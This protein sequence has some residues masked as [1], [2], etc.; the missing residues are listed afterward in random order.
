MRFRILFFIFFI[1]IFLCAQ[2]T[3]YRLGRAPFLA[4]FNPRKLSQALTAGLPNDSLKVRSI[5]L[6]TT[7]HIRYDVKAFQAGRGSHTSPGAIL[8][9]RKTVCLGYSILFDS[10]CKY[11]DINAQVVPG[12]VYEPWYE[13]RD[14]F[15]LDSHAWNVVQVDGEWKII[16][17][18][19]ASGIVKMKRQYFRK[20]LE[21]L[22]H[23]PYRQK[24]KYKKKRNDNYF[25]ARP[26]KFVLDHLPSSPAWQL[27]DCSVPID[28]FQWN[29][30][31]TQHFLDAPVNCKNGFDSI[32]KI[33]TETE[34][35]QMIAEGKEAVNYNRYNHQDISLGYFINGMLILQDAEDTNKNYMER[36]ALYDSVMLQMDSAAFSFMATSHDA[37]REENYFLRRNQRMK[38]QVIAENTPLIKRQE[39]EHKQ[40]SKEMSVSRK[41]IHHLDVENEKLKLKSKIIRKQK[42]KIDR[43]EKALVNEA[44]YRAN[45]EEAI[46]TN[47]DDIAAYQDSIS[48]VTF[49]LHADEAPGYVA[50][51]KKKRQ[52]LQRELLAQRY[53]LFYR[54]FEYNSFDTVLILQKKE[55]FKC[56]KQRDSIGENMRPAGKWV[57]DSSAALYSHYVKQMDVLMKENMKYCKQLGK[58]NKA[59]FNEKEYYKETR[60]KYIEWNDSLIVQNKLRMAAYKSYVL[61]LDK[62]GGY[63]SD[64]KNAFLKELKIENG[65]VISSNAFFKGYYG[66]NAVS[67]STDEKKC[68]KLKKYAQSRKQFLIKQEQKKEKA[69]AQKNDSKIQ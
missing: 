10:L 12:Y 6:W 33:T 45:L 66:G 25:F 37:V 43:P 35:R 44:A 1:P 64:S 24:L 2:V 4:S 15:Y 53:T 57:V 54:Q 62:T 29:P 69:A 59:A 48:H 49:N 19:W 65:R 17:V 68:M 34:R 52:I 16:D 28:S 36:I 47:E 30:Q 27:L 39:K 60:K 3:P 20:T 41:M 18:T 50:L 32:P 40:L 31:A 42:I 56:E 8:F 58:L 26:E 67:F 11:A 14:T 46:H 63:Y 51:E 61:S 23:I 7:H 21:F 22:F 9:F 13:A 55:I 5:Y 38:K